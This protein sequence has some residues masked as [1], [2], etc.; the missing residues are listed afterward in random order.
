M[1]NEEQNKQQHYSAETK[2]LFDL[3]MQGDSESQFG[4][5]QAF[6]EGNGLQPDT[7][8][9]IKWLRLAAA[10]GDASLQHEIA[11][12]FLSGE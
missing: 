5:A 11:L 4:L 10:S 12:I 6:I 1:N 3:A 7:T 2:I 8:E 9:A